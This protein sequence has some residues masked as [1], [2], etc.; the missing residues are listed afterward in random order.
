MAQPLGIKYFFDQG[1]DKKACLVVS[2]L[3]LLPFAQFAAVFNAGQLIF[4]YL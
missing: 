1:E 4:F 2:V 3:I